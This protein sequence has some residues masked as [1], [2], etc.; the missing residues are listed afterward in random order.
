MRRG[1]LLGLKWRDINFIEGIL[2]VRRIL[3]RVPTKMIKEVGQRYVSQSKDKKEP[4]PYPT[5]CISTRC[6]PTASREATRGQRESG[7]RPGKIMIMCFAL[8]WENI[9]ILGMTH[10]SD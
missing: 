5:Y 3:N 8:L 1:E 10:W 7:V 4:P 6:S 9:F 2:Q